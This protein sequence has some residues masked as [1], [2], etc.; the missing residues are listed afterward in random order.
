MHLGYEAKLLIF[1]VYLKLTVIDRFRKFL[2]SDLNF[3]IFNFEIRLIMLI[4]LW[5]KIS[6]SLN[7]VWLFQLTINVVDVAKS[8]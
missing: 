7:Y 5:Q 2:L 3:L 6:T 8:F 4:M 1:Y